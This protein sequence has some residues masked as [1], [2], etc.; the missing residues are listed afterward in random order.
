MQPER[1]RKIERIFS[2]AVAVSPV[3]RNNFLA[4]TCGDDFDLREE[5]SSMLVEDSDEEFLS[6]PIFDLGAQLL[7]ADDLPREREFGSYQLQKLLGR[8]GMGAV[9]LGERTDGKFSQQ[10]AVKLLKRELNTTDIRRRF[11]HERQI[12]AQLAHPN[13]ARLLDAG[14]TDDGLPFLVMEYVEGLPVNEF[15]DEQMLDLNERLEIFRMI[16]EAVSFAHRN[17]IVH[18]DLKPSNILVTKDGIPKLLDFGISKLLTPEFASDSAHTV[19][20][21]GAMTPEYASP[22]QLRG[23]SVTTARMFIHSA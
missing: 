13:I 14:T 3:D 18:R 17:L 15:C 22:E 16:C 5:I 20:K 21:L 19:T 11:R 4:R 12:L 9:Y 10:V 6:E 7:D 1:W 8:G 23:E 2:Q